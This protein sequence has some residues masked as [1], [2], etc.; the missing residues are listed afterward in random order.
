MATQNDEALRV[1]SYLFSQGERYTFAELWPR[2]MKARMSVID[3]AEG[4][5]Q[6]QAE[7]RPDADEWSVAEVLHHLTVSSARVAEVIE[8]LSRGEEIAPRRIDPP[9]EETSLS[10]ERLREMLRDDAIAWS[11]M[12]HRLPPSPP[13]AP[14]APHMIFGELHARAWYLFQR[15]HDLDHAGQIAK[16]K[17]AAGYPTE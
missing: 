13:T 15:V 5:T 11:A 14:T 3:A 9:R 6:A 2:M 16:N 12:T 17:A 8:A 4:V 10:V 7:F 1:R